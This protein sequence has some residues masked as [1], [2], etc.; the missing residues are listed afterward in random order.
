MEENACSV[1]ELKGCTAH[2]ER[3]LYVV[4]DILYCTNMHGVFRTPIAQRL[5]FIDVIG[6]DELQFATAAASGEIHAVP[7]QGIP[8][9]V[10][11]KENNKEKEEPSIDHE[12]L[13]KSWY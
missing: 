13:S 5:P 2:V 1:I 6:P 9:R 10:V 8:R 12:I 3:I 11:R 4:E 7:I